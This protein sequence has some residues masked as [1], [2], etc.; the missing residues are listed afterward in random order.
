MNAFRK[1][2]FITFTGAD[3]DTD[4][5][6][7]EW[8]ASHYPI[9]W[10]LLF[11]PKRQGAEPRY[12]SLEACKRFLGAPLRLAAHLC[13][14][15]SRSIMEGGHEELPLWL[16]RFGRVQVNHGRPEPARLRR[17]R[18]RSGAPMV[19]MQ[20]RSDAF[21]AMWPGVDLLY[22]RSGGHG[23]VPS[24]WPPHP[25]YLVGYAGGLGPE[26]VREA[27]AAIGAAGPYWIDME[28]GVR[29]DDRFD[30]AKCRSVCEH[31]FGA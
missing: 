1:P 14:G 2:E 15:Y 18:D 5:T 9:E 26:N 6:S 30:L 24:A 29:T 11:S 10:G 4:P 12:P 16:G 28:S 13:G 31:V 7:M 27:L 19:I 3:A 8:L 23:A 25:G 22:D 17:F 21:P 20:W